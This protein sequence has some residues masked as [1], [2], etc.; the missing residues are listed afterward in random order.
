[1]KSLLE[2][3]ASFKKQ[4]LTTGVFSDLDG[5]LSKIA[6]S[7]GDAII[8]SDIKLLLERLRA[9]YDLVA[10][11]TGR[12]SCNAAQMVG[13]NNLIYV[14][15]H[16][17]ELYNGHSCE[18]A[19]EVSKYP[20]I[21]ER[22]TRELGASKVLARITGLQVEGKRFGVAV[23]YRQASD[24]EKAKK[25]IGSISEPLAA[26]YGFRIAHGKN[27]IELKPKTECN[28]GTAVRELSEK[29]HLKNVLYFGDDT[30]DI[31]AFV[32]LRR[33]REDGSART[34]SVAVSS[35][36]VDRQVINEAD[37]AIAGIEEMPGVLEC[38][39]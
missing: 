29:Y 17:L 32:E 10:I 28:I 8:D 20:E 12:D 35:S 22:V 14:G 30:T 19:P 15:N 38:L 39:L 24:K 34:L 25:C 2:A 37:Y 7:P 5:T 4:A 23:H 9:V 26:R 11:V 33:M 21:A 27:V 18:I 6:P 36:E 3:I 13:L 16:G 1:M 31:D